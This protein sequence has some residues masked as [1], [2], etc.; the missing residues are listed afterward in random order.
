MPDEFRQ[1]LRARVALGALVLFEDLVGELGAGFEGERLGE[2][3]GVVAVEEDLL[4]LVVGEERG[5]VVLPGVRGEKEVVT[6]T[7]GIFADGLARLSD[8]FVRSGA[9]R[10]ALWLELRGLR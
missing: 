9:G 6:R 4:D 7:T 10:E 5:L 2:D 8:L 1:E 3:E